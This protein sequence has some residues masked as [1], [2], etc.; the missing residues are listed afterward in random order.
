VQKK[1]VYNLSV[2]YS[3]LLPALTIAQVQGVLTS[4]AELALR[5]D[6][7][8]DWRTCIE[9]NV[10]NLAVFTSGAA[11]PDPAVNQADYE[12]HF[13]QTHNLTFLNDTPGIRGVACGIPCSPPRFIVNWNTRRPDTPVHELGHCVGLGHAGHTVQQIMCEGAT[14]NSNSNELKKDDV[15]NYD[16]L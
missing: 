4:N 10:A 15:D 6:S 5:K 16:D 1:K 2:E 9:I 12:L 3:D 11:R 7:T 13:G 8:N 14:R